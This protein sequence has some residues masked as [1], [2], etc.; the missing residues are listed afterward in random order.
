[1]PNSRLHKLYTGCKVYII[2]LLILQDGCMKNKR[3]F[4]F[5]YMFKIVYDQNAASFCGS[6]GG[7]TGGKYN[8]IM[9]APLKHNLQLGMTIP[10]PE[11]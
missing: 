3:L 10:S 5:Y 8:D 6:C 11:G 9:P 4:I 7:T 1:M 2:K